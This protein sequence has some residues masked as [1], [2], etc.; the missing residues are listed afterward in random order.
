[1]MTAGLLVASVLAAGIA[2]AVPTPGDMSRSVAPLVD[3]V[4]GSVVTIQSTKIIRRAQREDPLT[5]YLRER[6]G[7]GGGRQQQQTQQSLGSGFVLDKRG[8]VLTNNHV[9]AGADEV[10]VLLADGRSFDARVEG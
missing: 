5:Q 9:V 4:K 10:K 8:I 1:M 7:M 2:Q 6:F 3:R